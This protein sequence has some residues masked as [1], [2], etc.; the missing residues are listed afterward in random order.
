MRRRTLQSFGMSDF[1]KLE[2]WRKAH[3]L[4]LN[5]HRVATG[6]RGANYSGLR[7]QMIRAAMSIPTNIVEGNGQRTKPEF[8]RFVRIAIN[9]AS[10]LEYHLIVARD[11]QLIN[12]TDFTALSAQT[13]EVRKMMH[14]L[15]RHLNI[16]SPKTSAEEGPD[17]VV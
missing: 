17:A 8:G 3:A 6:I 14:G 10:E 4:S 16:G 5:V 2:V 9:S 15:L 1:K 13:M 7:S 11:A 12:A